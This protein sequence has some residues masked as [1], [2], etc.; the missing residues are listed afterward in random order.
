[1][2]CAVFILV[3]LA[4]TAARADKVADGWL[5]TLTDRV[6]ADLAAGKPLVVQAHVPLCE[7]TIINCGNKK[8]GDG[9]SPDDNLYWAASWAGSGGAARAGSRC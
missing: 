4:T 7:R 3:I 6:V 9:E 5:D 2:R 1:M 8:L